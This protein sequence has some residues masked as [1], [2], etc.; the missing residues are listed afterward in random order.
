MINM[1]LHLIAAKAA[2]ALP[3]VTCSQPFGEGC[4]VYK[5][6]DK[7]FLLNSSLSGAALSNLK[8]TPDHGAMLRSSV[9]AAAILISS[10]PPKANIIKA[11]I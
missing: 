2:L 1:S 11:S 6:M 5:V 9:S 3:E 4:D 7:M 8:V 10:I